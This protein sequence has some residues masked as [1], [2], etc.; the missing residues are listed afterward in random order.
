VAGSP[1]AGSEAAGRTE[2]AA[3]E[4]YQFAALMLGDEA[5]A[6]NLVETTVA[7]VEVDPCADP[8]AARDLVQNR[9]LDGALQIMQRHDPASFAEVPPGGAIGG[10]IEEDTV[11]LSGTEL[12]DLI[13]GSGRGTLRAWLGRL[14]QAQRA[15]FVQ[16]AVMG[17]SN[18]DTALA[19]NRHTRPSM[20]TAEAVS[21]LFR[22]ALCSLTSS[23]LHAMPTAQV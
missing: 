11:P 2:S 23:L 3:V 7:S 12:S 21:G 15:V 13:S 17:R 14:T 22:Q 16:R 18:A 5:E 4:M 20:W 9:V 19:M 10:C 8:A 1:C 6:L